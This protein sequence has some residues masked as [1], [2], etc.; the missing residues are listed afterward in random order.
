MAVSPTEA[1]FY[2]GDLNGTLKSAQNVTTHDNARLTDKFAIGGY[3]DSA[4][5]LTTRRF[6]GV[7]DEP[8]VF[9]HTLTAEEVTQLYQAGLSGTSSAPVIK[10][11][12]ANAEGFVG[13]PITVSVSAIG[14]APLTYVWTKDGEIIEGVNAATLVLAGEKADEGTYHVT[15]SN[16]FGTAVSMEAVVTLYYKPTSVDLTG[17]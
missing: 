15:V 5:S 14:T 10:T 9:A 13:E 6:K 12:P 4:G 7:I 17:D 11:Q 16:D 1:T 2:L 8:V 3:I